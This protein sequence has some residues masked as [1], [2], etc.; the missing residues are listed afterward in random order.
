MTWVTARITSTSSPSVAPPPL[1]LSL[2]FPLPLALSLSLGFREG[3]SAKGKLEGGEMRGVIMCEGEEGRDDG[4]DG[5]VRPPVFVR[6]DQSFLSPTDLVTRTRTPITAVECVLSPRFARERT[7]TKRV[8]ETR[9]PRSFLSLCC[10]TERSDFLLLSPRLQRPCRC[11]R[12]CRHRP[13]DK[14]FDF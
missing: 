7:Q 8:P 3:P 2:S 12:L 4:D 5:G 10:V 1:P 9:P 14:D 6:S 13:G 11:Q